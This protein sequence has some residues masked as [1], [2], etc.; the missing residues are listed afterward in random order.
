MRFDVNG[1]V[2]DGL[3]TRHWWH[4]LLIACHCST[5]SSRWHFLILDDI[6]TTVLELLWG[7]PIAARHNLA[8]ALW[9]RADAFQFQSLLVG[10]PIARGKVASRRGRDF[11]LFGQSVL[12]DAAAP[13][14]P[15]SFHSAWLK[16]QPA[17]MMAYHKKARA[18]PTAS[19]SPFRSIV[20]Y[21]HIC[22]W[23]FGT[24]IS[25]ILSDVYS[26][27]MSCILS[28]IFFLAFHLA[29]SWVGRAA[30]TWQ[31]RHTARVPRTPESW[32]ACANL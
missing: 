12:S 9:S 21:Y 8:H 16:L 23:R 18:F 3:F 2:P 19:D 7:L 4:F 27:I 15:G 13:F 11:P 20:V 22:F 1:T 25:G 30:K 26:Y 28:D 14:S 32:R 10:P 6:G 31:T 5:N 17:F 24:G 29:Q